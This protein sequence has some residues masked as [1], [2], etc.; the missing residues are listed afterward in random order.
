MNADSENYINDLA[1]LIFEFEE[2]RCG[3]IFVGVARDEAVEFCKDAAKLV[4]EKHCDFDN[5]LQTWAKNRGK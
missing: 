3:I 1:K 5:K 4:Y 2:E